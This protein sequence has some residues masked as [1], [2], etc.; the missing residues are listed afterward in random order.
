MMRRLGLLLPMIML[1]WTIGCVD[2]SKFVTPERREQGL[3]V[4]LPGIEGKSSLNRDVRQGLVR[5]GVY[6][7]MPIYPWGRPIP[8]LGPL[9]NQVDFIGNRL[10]GISI[11]KMIMQYQDAYPGR[12]VYVVGHSGGGGVAVFVAEAMPEDRQIDGLVLLSASISSAYNLTKA[13]GRCRNGIVNFYNEGD[14]A[15]LGIGTTV[16]GNVDGTHGP[17]AGLISFDEPTAGSSK[18]KK[19]AYENL[20]QIRVTPSMSS[21]DPHASTTRPHFVSAHVAKWMLASTWPATGGMLTSI[22][23]GNLPL[24]RGGDTTAK[25]LV[26]PVR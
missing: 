17:S 26:L 14:G 2:N 23:R 7:A 8:G 12:P 5:G 13:L 11:S 19:L 1:L 9:L 3:V 18:K 15:L 10:A 6:C 21:G 20:Y 16:F 4:I 24:G 22:D 25:A